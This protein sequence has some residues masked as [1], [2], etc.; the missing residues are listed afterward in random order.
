MI[1]NLFKIAYRHI[2]R[3]QLYTAINVGGLAIG[4][5]C[6]ML[7][8]L[9]VRKELS[10]DR[11]HQ[12]SSKIYRLVTDFETADGTTGL[13]RSAPAWAANLLE[14]RS[15]VL[16]AVRI[17]GARSWTVSANTNVFYEEGWVFADPSF[18][19]VFSFEL[20]RGDRESALEGIN[21]VAVS[22]S[23]ANKYFGTDAAVGKVITLD[24]SQQFQVSAVFEDLP[25]NS[26]FHFDFVAT[27]DNVQPLFP[28]MEDFHQRQRSLLVQTYLL[29]TDEN[30]VQAA[31][32][33]F[34]ERHVGDQSHNGFNLHANLQPITDIHLTSG[35][36]DEWES[37]GSMDT[38]YIFSVVAVFILLMASINFINIATAQASKRAKEVGVKK[39]LGSYRW[40][41]GQQYIFETVFLSLIA[42][43]ISFGI[44]ELFLMSL[45]FIFGLELGLTYLNSPLSFLVLLSIALLTGLVAGVYPAYYLTKFKAIDVLKG[46][47]SKGGRSQ[48]RLRQ[49]LTLTQYMVAILMVVGTIVVSSQLQFINEKE[50]GLNKENVLMVPL[51]NDEVAEQFL[52][53]SETISGDPRIVSITN[54]QQGP[55]SQIG[56]EVF[57]PLGGDAT[58]DRLVQRFNVD[59]N[60]FS[61]LG[62]KVLA[63]RE[64]SAQFPGD[65]I[66]ERRGGAIV[67]NE[68]AMREFG[69]QTPQEAIGQEIRRVELERSRMTVIGVVDNFHSQSLHG[70]IGPMTFQYGGIRN[71]S[72]AYIRFATEDM[73]VLID[74]LQMQWQSAVPGYAFTFE[75]LEDRLNRWYSEEQQLLSLLVVFSALAVV[76]AALGI[77]G[78]A[79]FNAEQR[80]KEIGI[81]KVLGASA[82]NIVLML[83]K[84]FTLIVVL[85]SLVILPI[86]VYFMQEWLSS[87][88]YRISLGPLPFLLAAGVAL[89]VT[90][91]AVGFR[92][93]QAASA[94]PVKS[95]RED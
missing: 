22:S 39:S 38:V 31:L 57:R 60:F 71:T 11:F 87:F 36:Q 50:L 76:I 62:I 32:P 18:F 92:S 17:F 67:I 64:F 77:F 23:M 12:H 21:K 34:I 72:Q 15:D 52:S 70:Y 16:N 80:T 68:I 81:R 19:E 93:M 28:R 85:A 37:N 86:A 20:L 45:G 25:D 43:V 51:A 56:E 35:L 47:M 79:T 6:F 90:W 40:Q 3:N 59:F 65:T 33:D 82:N 30:R 46:K 1:S 69:W 10:Y 75:F 84:E 8:F 48:K 55:A 13:A 24:N 83:N 26:H 58:T 44:S 9:F 74:D 91:L 49:G 27:M 95:L 61:T 78:L 66:D 54:A 29:L 41:I 94:N 63:G 5:A 89:F 42:G 73:A 53:F 7:I 4:L 14:E 88:A 2:L